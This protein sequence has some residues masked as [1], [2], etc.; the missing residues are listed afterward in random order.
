MARTEKIMTLEILEKRGKNLVSR[1]L[2]FLRIFEI[3]IME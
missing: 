3:A 2:S 1:W